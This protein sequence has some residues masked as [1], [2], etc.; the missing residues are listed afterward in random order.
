MKG[1]TSKSVTAALLEKAF[2]GLRFS[3]NLTRLVL[4]NA[5]FAG[6]NNM[7]FQYL[8]NT[9]M[10]YLRS[11]GSKVEVLPSGIF[12]YLPNLEHLDLQSNW[13]HTIGKNALPPHNKLINLDLA[14][15]RLA[16]VPD[17]TDANLSNLK[18]LVLK[19]NFNEWLWKNSLDGYK[20][21]EELYLDNNKIT[22]LHHPLFRYGSNLQTLILSRNRIS[23]ITPAAFVGLQHL[24]DLLLDHNDIVFIDPA[25]FASTPNLKTLELSYNGRLTSD[26]K[27]DFA[28][29]FKPLHKLAILQIIEVGLKAVPKDIFEH[30]ANLTILSMSS[31]SLSTLDPALF[32]SLKKLNTLTIKENQ[33]ITLNREVIDELPNLQ[34]LDAS[35]NV[36]AC[37]CSIQW[38]ADWIRLGYVYVRRLDSTICIPPKHKNKV[39]LL[40][41]HLERECM[42]FAFYYA[43]WLGLVCYMCLVALAAKLYKLRWYIR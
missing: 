29:L 21:L 43:Y 31:N 8:A 24:T 11:R 25:A 6:L 39:S 18:S 4:D 40:N 13:I 33:L 36:F 38:F 16:R 34:L 15:N 26:I 42:S 23:T 27:D 28:K 12:Y 37:D 3:R 41:L 17:A 22:T 2:Y 19:R 14:K 32:H 35:S 9:S 5:N 30:M 20:M 10:K 1:W 7:T